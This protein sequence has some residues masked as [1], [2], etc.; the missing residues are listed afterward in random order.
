MHVADIRRDRASGWR[1]PQCFGAVDHAIERKARRGPRGLADG[2]R[3]RKDVVKRR[4]AKERVPL[5]VDVPRGTEEP[6]RDGEGFFDDFRVDRG[7]THPV[8]CAEHL[9]AQQERC[10]CGVAKG[11]VRM[12]RPGPR[13]TEAGLVREPVERDTCIAGS[14]L[15]FRA[16]HMR[17]GAG[18]GVLEFPGRAKHAEGQGGRITGRAE[19]PDGRHGVCASSI[20]QPAITKCLHGLD[21]N[22]VRIFEN[23][24]GCA[25]DGAGILHNK[26]STR[27]GCAS[28]TEHRAELVAA[29]RLGESRSVSTLSGAG[30]ERREPVAHL[31]ALSWWSGHGKG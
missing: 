16:A 7:K 3:A 15:V 30:F 4:V 17:D 27:L 20:E 29:L 21:G 18:R 8:R 23:P 9:K 19:V 12:A 22:C 11:V 25:F 14:A 1:C 10:Q 31:H 2:N 24:I 6:D 13:Q 5:G 28:N 26:F